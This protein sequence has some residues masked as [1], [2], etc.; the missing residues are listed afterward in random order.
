LDN[1]KS[2]WLDAVHKDALLWPQVSDLK[3]WQSPAANKYGVH[4]IPMNFLIDPKGVIVAKGLR[5]ASLE[6][7]LREVLPA[8]K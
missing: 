6:D 8:G 5:G 2:K 3:G 4:S 1:S 7:K